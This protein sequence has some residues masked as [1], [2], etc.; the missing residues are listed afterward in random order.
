MSLSPP[1]PD[2][3]LQAFRTSG[4]EQT[5]A[6]LRLSNRYSAFWA[7]STYRS[8]NRFN[9]FYFYSLSLRTF[10]VVAFGVGAYLLLCC[11]KIGIFLGRKGGL[12]WLRH[13]QTFIWASYYWISKA[14]IIPHIMNAKY[15]FS[16]QDEPRL[17]VSL[18]NRYP[19]YSTDILVISWFSKPSMRI[20]LKI[21]FLGQ[22]KGID[23]A[24]WFSC[25]VPT[26]VRPF[27][28]SML[29]AY[30]YVSK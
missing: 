2:L 15:E 22:P 20:S 13:A 27:Q 21:L 9:Q 12:V 25:Y 29:T 8:H 19:L 11:F 17:A 16:T 30:T 24:S 5:S 14:K 1:K 28:N 6:G 26:T 3:D 4:Q 7:G 10:D 23:I 18:R